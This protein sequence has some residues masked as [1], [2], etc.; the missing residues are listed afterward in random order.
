MQQQ[1]LPSRDI[2]RD[3]TEYTQDEKIQA[4]YI[5]KKESSKDY[6]RDYEDMTEKNLREYEEKKKKEKSFDRLTDQLQIPIMISLL[7]LVFQLPIINSIVFKKFSF[8]S[9][10]DTDGNFNFYGLLLKSILFGGAYYSI[11]YATNFISDL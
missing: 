1:R 7:Y 2:P 5:P 10:Y 6:V 9:I 3:T 8:L 11:Q 4:N